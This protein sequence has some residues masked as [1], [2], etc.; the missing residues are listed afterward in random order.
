MNLSVIGKARGEF[1]QSTSNVEEIEA[2][3]YTKEEVRNLLKTER[4]AARTQAYC[5]L[6]ANK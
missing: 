5:Y 6:W 2:G 4:F 3:W 1:R